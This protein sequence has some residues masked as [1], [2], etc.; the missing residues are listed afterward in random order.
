MKKKTIIE[1]K[2]LMYQKAAEKVKKKG[3]GTLNT[4]L[5][6]EDLK[7]NMKNPKFKK[8]FNSFQ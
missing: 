4:K 2:A 8:S 3:T 5:Y 7:R 6:K 1:A